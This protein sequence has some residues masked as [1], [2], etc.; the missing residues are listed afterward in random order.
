[1]LSWIPGSAISSES[2]SGGSKQSKQRAHAVL[3]PAGQGEAAGNGQRHYRIDIDSGGRS[4]RVVAS[5]ACLP[6]LGF[7]GS[8]MTRHDDS[9]RSDRLAVRV[10]HLRVVDRVAASTLACLAWGFDGSMM[11]RHD[12]SQRSGQLAVTVGD[13]GDVRVVPLAPVFIHNADDSGAKNAKRRKQD[14]EIKAGY[15]AV[16]RIRNDQPRLAAVIVAD[17]PCSK[18]PFIEQV[19]AARCSFL[20]VAK[21]EDHTSLYQDIDGLRRG[22]LLD[23]RCTI[24][25][26]GDRHEYEWVTGVPLNGNPAVPRST[27]CTTASYG[28]ARPPIKTPG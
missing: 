1:M 26:T 20:L 24:D 6:R 15:R 27:S 16:Q 23:H 7:D 5:I 25:A 3:D 12:D 11:T 10:G 19:R 9:Q 21:P 22:R 2:N 4:D 13:L 8:M 17:S 14:C 28:P 18:Q